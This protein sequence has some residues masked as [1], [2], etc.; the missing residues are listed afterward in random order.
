MARNDDPEDRFRRLRNVLRARKKGRKRGVG[1]RGVSAIASRSTPKKAEDEVNV[2]VSGCLRSSSETFR[3][4]ALLRANQPESR[5]LTPPL[6]VVPSL[7]VCP[8]LMPT[9]SRT[10]T[11]PPCDLTSRDRDGELLLGLNSKGERHRATGRAWLSG[12]ASGVV[13]RGL[14]LVQELSWPWILGRDKDKRGR[15]TLGSNFFHLF[16]RTIHA[17]RYASWAVRRLTTAETSS[18]AS[19]RCSTKK[20]SDFC[21]C[22]V[23]LPIFSLNPASPAATTTHTE[24]ELGTRS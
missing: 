10:K 11:G 12:R 18:P 16:P 2:R 24:R 9:G 6:L 14:W 15:S 20:Q 4:G 1:F 21:L 7:A 22:L 3:V 23:P 5:R 17:S 13:L 19:R 8:Y